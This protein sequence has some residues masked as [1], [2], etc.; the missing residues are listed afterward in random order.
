[1]NLL[2]YCF[3]VMF[4]YFGHEACRILVSSLTIDWTHT[5]CI[6][7]QSLKPPD[8]QGSTWDSTFSLPWARIWFQV[9]ELRSHNPN[10]VAEKKRNYTLCD[11][12]CLASFTW[13]AVFK[14]HPLCITYQCFTH[15]YDQIIF[16]CMV[17]PYLFIHS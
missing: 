5:L 10:D 4:W 11:L 17:I 7:R 3:C 9:R 16:H 12:L 14:V 1:M 15:F 6:G 2:Q 8:N 13:H